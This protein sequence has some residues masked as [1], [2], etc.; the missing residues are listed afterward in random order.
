M[1]LVLQ[2]AMDM[3]I[4]DGYYTKNDLKR[5]SEQFVDVNQ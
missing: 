4:P 2:K 1:H 3:I 5:V